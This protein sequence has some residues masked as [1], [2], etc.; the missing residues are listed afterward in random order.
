MIPL[1]PLQAPTPPD[2]MEP[3]CFAFAAALVLVVALIFF[4]FF[5]KDKD[6]R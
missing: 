6:G 1:L 4:V 3:S 5:H 2:N